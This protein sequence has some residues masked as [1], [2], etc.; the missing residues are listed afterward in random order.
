MIDGLPTA[1]K[2]QLLHHRQPQIEDILH[3]AL[4]VAQLQERTGGA[5]Q[6]QR[7]EKGGAQIIPV[8]LHLLRKTGGNGV[9]GPGA[10]VLLQIVPGV[11]QVNPPPHM[12]EELLQGAGPGGGLRRK[13]GRRQDAGKGVRRPV[14]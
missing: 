6:V 10:S 1:G 13:G 12:V 8:G 7:V 9:V 14:Q 3:G 5:G 2:D 11:H 4:P